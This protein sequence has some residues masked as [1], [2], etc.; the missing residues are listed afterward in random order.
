[1]VIPKQKYFKALSDQVTLT[2]S[3]GTTIGTA[4]LDA[5]DPTQFVINN[6]PS[7]PKGTA[8]TIKFNIPIAVDATVDGTL[9]K[10]GDPVLIRDN[11]GTVAGDNAQIHVSNTNP[12]DDDIYTI[13]YQIQNS[14][15]PY[16]PPAVP[17]LT[18]VPDLRF[19]NTPRFFL[20]GLAAANPTV[21]EL[22]HGSYT[23]SDD[24]QQSANDSNTSNPP[25]LPYISTSG[26]FDDL[27]APSN[28]PK[29][30]QLLT[31]AYNNLTMSTQTN[32]QLLIN[33]NNTK[34]NWNL[35]LQLSPFKSTGA[36]QQPLPRPARIVFITEG[37]STATSPA[38]YLPKPT[39]TT[40]P[41]LV[42]DGTSTPTTILTNSTAQSMKSIGSNT[43]SDGGFQSAALVGLLYFDQ[44]L[45][46]V[47]AG[48]YTSTATWTLSTTP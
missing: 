2:N 37:T 10:G 25:K 29:S 13:Q 45:P 35:S 32:P 33:G 39:D 46:T 47:Q 3:A 18:T 19:I 16:T 4:T 36:S 30:P 15:D 48:S 31:A 42:T 21:S 5:S 40:H 12:N 38:S 20:S 43:S 14:G 28:N 1:M 41:A 26:D 34:S 7:F 22:I 44:K 24:V 27:I 23:R 17:E 11:T 8:S 6:L 9:P